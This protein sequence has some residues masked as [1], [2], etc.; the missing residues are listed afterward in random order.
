MKKIAVIPSYKPNEKLISIL[1]ELKE[2]KIECIVVNDGSSDKYDS[3]FNKVKDYAHLI[4]YYPN[5]G[6]GYAI[7][8][9]LKYIEKTYKNSVIVTIDSDGEHRPK[10]AIKLLKIAEKKPNTL[11]L[12]KNT[13]HKLSTSITNWF[14]HFTTGVTLQ[15]TKS[16][17]RA[18]QDKLIPHFLTIDGNRF[19]YE[20]NMLLSCPKENIDIYEE[21]IE[22]IH[23][24]DIASNYNMIK[25]TYL[26]Y[27]KMIIYTI[28][29]LIAAVVDFFV[30]LLV[31]YL[32]NNVTIS[33]IL[34]RVTSTN[35]NYIAT[36]SLVFKDK[37]NA[38]Q[39]VFKYYA[40][41]IATL[42]V[43]TILLHIAVNI[44]HMNKY[45]FKIVIDTILFLLNWSFANKYVFKT[46][47]KK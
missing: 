44:F 47:C 12:G 8:E 2:N 14:Y 17:L 16:G 37:R 31:V 1:K 30:Y 43:S 38:K 9:G 40:L 26:I 29:S 28:T 41:A 19:D 25:D 4:E 35:V 6:K 10:D 34:A 5:K 32:T 27:R 3:I 13:K 45:I 42:L 46:S 24:N 7:K 11:V 23:D 39:S 33:N 21:P 20:M 36:K 22:T 18:F 15:D